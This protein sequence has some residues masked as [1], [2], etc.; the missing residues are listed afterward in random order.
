MGGSTVVLMVWESSPIF[1]TFDIGI[2]IKRT[3]YPWRRVP[4]YEPC[5]SSSG[6]IDRR[7]QSSREQVT[8][9]RIL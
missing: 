2:L 4:P 7:R 8:F 3:S 6:V 9:Y 1:G 5:V